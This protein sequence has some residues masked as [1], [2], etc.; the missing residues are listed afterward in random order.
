MHELLILLTA[1]VILIAAW[2]A[3][4]TTRDPFAPM[5]VFSPMLMYMF[6]YAPWTRLRSAGIRR[7]FPNTEALEIVF[8]AFFLGVT[9]FCI[10]L[11]WGRVSRRA[12][13][14]RFE[15]LPDGISKNV[16]RKLFQLACL[17]GITANAAHWYM[18]H[19]SGGWS[20]VF[21]VA[22]PYLQTPSGYI[23]E[24]PMLSY[25]ALLMLAVAWQGKRMTV[26]RVLLFL[27]IAIPQLNMATF[28]G[29]RG[30]MFLIVCA[31]A[32]CWCIVH[33]RRPRMKTVIAGGIALGVVLLLLGGNRSNLFKPWEGEVDFS[34]VSDRLTTNEE[35]TTGDEFVAGSAMI[36]ASSELERHYWGVRYF[37][38]FFVRPIP[39]AIWPTKYHDMGLGWMRDAPGSSGIYDSEWVNLLGFIPA[40]GNA[41]GFIPDVFLEFSWGMVLACFVI[42]RIYSA[43]WKRWRTR[44]G[45]WIFL[46]FE[47][48]ILSVYLPSQ[49]V[50]AWLYR[51]LILGFPTWLIWKRVIAPTRKRVGFE[52]SL[53]R[54]VARSPRY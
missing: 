17:M 15:L 43:C 29:R 37:T 32:G 53:G 33:S 3:L 19:Y 44:G 2:R 22:K 41:G 45:L 24:L 38:T 50:G 42:G 4:T 14:R 7:F 54:T 11:S 20:S 8:V 39:S 16:R 51:M 6:V 52:G 48:L 10:G 25:P 23:G 47:L 21:G 28:G 46:Y 9:S 18:I 40:G 5:V 31:L 30:P 13:D 1:A 27:L 35:L 49:S 12:P 26:P 34:V 36:I